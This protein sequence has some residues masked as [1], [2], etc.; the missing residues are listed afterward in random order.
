M[1]LS[2]ALPLPVTVS[3]FVVPSLAEIATVGTS[4]LP[5]AFS[6]R[7]D[8]S[9]ILIQSSAKLV[10]LIEAQLSLISVSIEASVASI[11]TVRFSAV[12]VSSNLLTFFEEVR[13]S[14]CF[15]LSY[16]AMPSSSK[17][18][19]FEMSIPSI[20]LPQRLHF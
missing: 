8:L 2:I 13:V 3:V 1:L 5:S 6:L 7:G 4:S 9:L 15:A 14:F 12:P 19:K 20:V 18:V 10:L 11:Y 16:F 17:S